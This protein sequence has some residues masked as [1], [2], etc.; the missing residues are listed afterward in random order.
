MI[1][2]AHPARN[3]VIAIAVSVG[4]LVSS[5]TPALDGSIWNGSDLG[6]W[7][8]DQALEQGCATGSIMLAD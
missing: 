8:R 3:I 4:F 5:C 1:R 7:V 2:K 6:K